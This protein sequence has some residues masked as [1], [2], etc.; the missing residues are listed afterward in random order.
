[1]K[2]IRIFLCVAVW[3]P[4]VGG[5][6]GPTSNLCQLKPPLTYVPGGLS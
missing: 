2:A 5:H 6:I 1:M 4:Q 3:G